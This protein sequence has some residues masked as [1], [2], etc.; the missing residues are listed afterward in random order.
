MNEFRQSRS[1]YYNQKGDEEERSDQIDGAK[2]PSA[3]AQTLD[4]PASV[5]FHRFV[6]LGQVLY[7]IQSVECD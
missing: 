3:T 7:T 5:A 2:G 4:S 1:K 6:M